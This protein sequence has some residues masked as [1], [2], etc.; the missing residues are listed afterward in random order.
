MAESDR[1]SWAGRTALVTGAGSGN[2][3]ATARALAKLGMRVIGC[4][5]N[6]E[7]LKVCSLLRRFSKLQ[8]PQNKLARMQS[9][10]QQEVLEARRWGM[11]TE[12]RAEMPHCEKA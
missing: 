2:G 11:Q 8:N 9:C 5:I 1:K 10:M 7:S 4:D 12:T 6:M 3:K